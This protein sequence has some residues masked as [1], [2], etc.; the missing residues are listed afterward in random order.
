MELF[1]ESLFVSRL[2]LKMSL[3][4]MVDV[5]LAMFAVGVFLLPLFEF[6]DVDNIFGELLLL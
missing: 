1:A 2:L 6:G 5:E 4:C 3:L